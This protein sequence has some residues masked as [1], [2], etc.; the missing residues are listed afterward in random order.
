MRT[1]DDVVAAFSPVPKALL[2]PSVLQRIDIVAAA[3]QNLVL[4]LLELVPESAD[5]TAAFRKI[6][7]A[8][9]TCT[10]AITHEPAPNLRAVASVSATPL[11]VELPPKTNKQELPHG[12]KNHNSKN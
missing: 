7:E 1:R 3:C 9:W 11:E 5:R 6:L 4:E 8:K 12:Q 10:Q 2:T